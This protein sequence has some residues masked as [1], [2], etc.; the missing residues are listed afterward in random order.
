MRAKRSFENP[1][2][3][4]ATGAGTRANSGAALRTAITAANLNFM[5]LSM[6][7]PES[8]RWRLIFAAQSAE[9]A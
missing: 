6:H 8:R 7:I 9:I 5:F 2:C 1:T 4:G 3:S